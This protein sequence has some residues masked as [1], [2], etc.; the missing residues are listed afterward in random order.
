MTSVASR[1]LPVVTEQS[2]TRQTSYVRKFMVESPL[3]SVEDIKDSDIDVLAT[4]V[5][6]L[7]RAL[8]RKVDLRIFSILTN[9]LEATPTLPLTNGAVTV[10]VTEGEP[11]NTKV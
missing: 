10:T 2:W 6:D 5:R 3:I 11:V 1:A 7:V 9:A 8:S 4:N